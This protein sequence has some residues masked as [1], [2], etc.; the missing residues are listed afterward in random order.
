[1]KKNISIFSF[2]KFLLSLSISLSMLNDFST[3]EPELGNNKTL[4]EFQLSFFY[5]KSNYLKNVS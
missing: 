4:F 1:M 3:S 2:L 5:Y